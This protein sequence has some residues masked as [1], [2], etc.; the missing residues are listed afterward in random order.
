M[1]IKVY[2]AN[3]DH[4]DIFL[5]VRDNFDYD[6]NLV[7]DAERLNPGEQRHFE[8]EANEDGDGLVSW[9]AQS[10]NDPEVVKERGPSLLREG[11]TLSVDLFGARKVSRTRTRSTG[12]T[13]SLV[14]GA[15]TEAQIKQLWTKVHRF[16][17]PAKV[18]AT[19]LVV[20]QQGIADVAID[21][22]KVI[23][24]KVERTVKSFKNATDK[25]KK[26][27]YSV[28]LT[29][30]RS[31]TAQWTQRITGSNDLKVAFNV[32]LGDAR[33]NA[34]L[35]Q[36]NSFDLTK[37]NTQVFSEDYT[38]TEKFTWKIPPR[39]LSELN[40]SVVK[41]LLQTPVF[42]FVVID[43]VV[44]LENVF[45]EVEENMTLSNFLQ[46]PADRQIPIRAELISETY[47]RTDIEQIDSP[48]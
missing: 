34:D 10:A 37:T 13:R 36:K 28:T 22:S 25:E 12:D 44:D 15:E 27:D 38:T 39:S 21:Q 9:V 41:G 20:L 4:E 32:P 45:G 14:I 33:I 31:E 48:L 19:K 17:G 30:R 26:W 5:W 47:Q 23:P 43:C 18:V 6:Q 40:V 42:G 29:T 24:G 8:I 35:L 16:G 46:S 11:E 7:I 2:V 1:K 3:E